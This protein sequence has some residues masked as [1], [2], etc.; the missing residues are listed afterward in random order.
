MS[1]TADPTP[2]DDNDVAR[3]AEA[4]NETES[5]WSKLSAMYEPTAVCPECRGTGTLAGGGV[6]GEIPCPTC[7]GGGAVKHPLADEIGQLALPDFKPAR[8]QLALMASALDKSNRYEYQK[9]NP[10]ADQEVV[11]EPPKVPSKGEMATLEKTISDLRE[12]GRKKAMDMLEEK[13]KTA[14]A[15]SGRQRR[16][17]ELDAAEPEFELDDDCDL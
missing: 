12:S 8:R 10:D 13:N 6:F 7:D 17:P 2:I 14:P 9:L 15:L 4:L 16:A 11:K 3:A 1:E 5:M